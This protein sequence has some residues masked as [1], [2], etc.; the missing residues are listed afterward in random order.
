MRETCARKSKRFLEYWILTFHHAIERN[1]NASV[2]VDVPTRFFLQVNESLDHAKA[3]TLFS[4]FHGVKLFKEG[5]R[6][7]SKRF[8]HFWT[9]LETASETQHNTKAR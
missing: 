7:L 6:V 8:V 9:K 2:E 5:K 4:R 3:A 1:V